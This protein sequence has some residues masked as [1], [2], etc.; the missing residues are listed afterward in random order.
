MASAGPPY[1]EGLL[2]WIWENQHYTFQ[3]LQTNDGQQVV[4]HFPGWPNQSDG[5]DFKAAEISIGKLRWYGDI[6]LHWHISDWESHHHHTDSNYDK[7]VLHVVYEETEQLTVRTDHSPIP[8]LCLAPFLSQPLLS[9]LQKYQNP[10]RLPCAGHFGEA[11]EEA[12]RRQLNQAHKEYFEQKVN[13]LLVFYSPSLAPSTAWKKMLVIALFDGLG[14]SYN[15]KPMQQLA[16]KLWPYMKEVESAEELQQIA[17]QLSSVASSNTHT[18]YQ[19]KH[20]GCRPGNHPEARIRQGVQCLWYIFLHENSHWR[21]GNAPLLWQ[22]LLNSVTTT[23]SLGSERSSILFGTVFLPALFILG[24]LVCSERLKS[25]SWQLWQSHR[26]SLPSSLLRLF[27]QTPLPP[28]LYTRK[29]GSIYQ[30]RTYCRPRKCQHCN[31][32]KFI[33]SS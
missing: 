23:P 9:F 3:G 17:L 19:W 14:I 28:E 2:H 15:R 29:L 26:A 8:T 12:F 25:E 10:P 30:L 21:T 20:K 31:V 16:H 13:A 24:N 27:E 1:H 7:V 4:V 33:I 11:F 22:E 6:E 5:P 32:F 18:Q